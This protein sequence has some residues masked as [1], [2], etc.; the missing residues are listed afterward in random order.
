MVT[1]TS[2]STMPSVTTMPVVFVPFVFHAPVIRVY[3]GL[4]LVIGGT[5]THVFSPHGPKYPLG[6]YKTRMG[7]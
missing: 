4:V 3:V 1:V 7:T 6:V 2:V 5:C